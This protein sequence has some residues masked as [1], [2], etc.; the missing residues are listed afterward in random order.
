MN[1]EDSLAEDKRS[2]SDRRKKD[3]FES[4]L[5]VAIRF[6][7][8][9]TPI[10]GVCSEIGPNGMR[11]RTRMPLIEA[12]YVR[13]NFKNASNSTFSEGRVVWTERTED[14]NSFES[15]IDIQ[16]WGGNNPTQEIPS[17]EPAMKPKKDRRQKKPR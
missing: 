10:D 17:V 5:E 14:Q 6:S 4:T 13:I 8:D 12:S 1:P 15:G 7:P 9:G 3:R 16:R 11:L 2:S